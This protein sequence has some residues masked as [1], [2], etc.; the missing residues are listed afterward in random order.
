MY[1]RDT[2]VVGMLRDSSST[3]L[4]DGCL[5]ICTTDCHAHEQADVAGLVLP[6]KLEGE[7]GKERNW[8]GKKLGC[9]KER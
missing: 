9:R 2:S 1:L 5:R 6:R 3:G 8:C 4:P 7:G